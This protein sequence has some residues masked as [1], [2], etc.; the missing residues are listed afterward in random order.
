MQDRMD[1]WIDENRPLRD[2][3]YARLVEATN[4]L[5]AEAKEIGP[6]SAYEKR[7]VL[8]VLTAHAHRRAEETNA[9]NPR[10]HLPVPDLL[11]VLVNSFYEGFVFG[12][13]FVQRRASTREAL[14]DR[15]TV[16]DVNHLL[17]H[18]AG[19]QDTIEEF[20]A[21]LVSVKTLNFVSV[22]RAFSAAQKLSAGATSHQQLKVMQASVWM[23]AFVLGAVFQ[24]LGGHRDV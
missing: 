1:A 6:E 12:V 14:S 17:Q 9:E 2:P 11:K 15:L 23:D 7:I 22:S 3:D 24:E 21:R 5:E 19:E 13:L 10:E 18:Q 20:Y 16:A 8:S 4:V